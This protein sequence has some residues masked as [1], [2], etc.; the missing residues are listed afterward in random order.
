MVAMAA[1][2]GTAATAVAM[3]VVAASAAATAAAAAATVGAAPHPAG[4]PFPL[5]AV[6]GTYRLSSPTGGRR[7]CAATV[8]TATAG[9]VVTHPSPAVWVVPHGVITAGGVPCSSPSSL[10]V[11][12]L[13]APAGELHAEGRLPRRRR[14]RQ[15]QGA[16][17]NDGNRRLA[18]LLAGAPAGGRRAVAA[19]LDAAVPVVVGI[20]AAPRVCGGWTLPAG[21]LVVWV[22]GRSSAGGAVHLG[23]GC[24][25][26]RQTPC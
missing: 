17:R 24:R 9:G 23:G 2:V 12:D 1:S 21:S 25:R 13:T 10:V 14:R 19:L 5:A 6:G 7:G 15:P 16:P 3:V 20:D 8:T 11:V 4:L 18:A 26:C 22:G